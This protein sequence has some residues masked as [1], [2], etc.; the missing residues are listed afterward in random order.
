M[1]FLK[2]I[3]V[4]TLLAYILFFVFLYSLIPFILTLL[5]N[6]ETS[7]LLY[8]TLPFLLLIQY[9]FIYFYLTKY[10]VKPINKI[11]NTLKQ[12]TDG[13]I[14]TDIDL[15][16]NNCAG[17]LIPEIKNMQKSLINTVSSIENN[18]NIITSS[19]DNIL[20][21]NKELVIRT[22]KQNNSIKNTSYN[23]THL[24]QTSIHNELKS[25]SAC[26]QIEH[27]INN[28][29][30]G[31]NEINRMTETMNNIQQSST[32][33][34]NISEFISKMAF[35]TNL[36]SLNAAVEAARA[37]ESGRGFAVVAGE[38]R[39]LAQSCSNSAKDIKELTDHAVQEIKHG[40]LLSSKNLEFMKENIEQLK[41]LNEYFSEIHKSS[42]E[43]NSQIDNI[44]RELTSINNNTTENSL[45]AENIYKLSE[46][47]KQRTN[48]MNDNINNIKC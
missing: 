2:N 22:D 18:T 41:A 14:D 16:G 35:Q 19:I 25:A 15:F 37:G 1:N 42:K 3:S 46:V 33:I 39:N 13:K 20:K 11:Q 44:N 29:N 34:K 9:L 40:V 48:F 32:E 7:Q 30:E 5:G 45:L 6:K 21:E 38:V 8:Q 17:K 43:Q 36:L 4:R 28:Y 24:N 31:M 10:L 27:L 23:M 26:E 12:I 47:I